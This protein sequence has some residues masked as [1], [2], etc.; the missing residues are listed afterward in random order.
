MSPSVACHAGLL[1]LLVAAGA[2]GSASQL[3]DRPRDDGR[4]ARLHRE[5]DPEAFRASAAAGRPIDVSSIDDDLL[6]AAVFHETNGR[7][8]RHG[9]PPLGYRHE[10]RE[11]ARIQAQDMA[12]AGRI[13]HRHRE[14]RF[15]T[16]RDRLR[17]LKLQPAFAAEN[18]ALSFG[19]QYEAG[20]PVVVREEG[21][22]TVFSYRAG[23]EP[24]PPHTYRSFAA[25]LLDQWMRS[26]GHRANILDARAEELGTAPVHARNDAGMDVFYSVQVFF[27]ERRD[28]PPPRH[29]GR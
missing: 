25:S 21:G 17:Q 24:I 23:G 5:L 6:A 13:G 14:R 29:R 18:V 1:V 27:A 16:L 20:R 2:V 26:R 9:L 3:T 12:R 11:A 19:I 4:A 15:Q 28:R 22:R 10:L 7:R 8:L